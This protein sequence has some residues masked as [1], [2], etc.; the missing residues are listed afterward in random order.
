MSY[1]VNCGVE[2]DESLTACPLCA[3]RVYHPEKEEI[4]SKADSPFPKEKGEVEKVSKL[5]NVIYIS[6]L[7]LSIIIT[8]TLLNVLVFN[9][10]WWSIP[11]NGICMMLW[12]FFITAVYSEKITIYVTLMSDL[13]A[14][15]L[16]LYLISVLSGSNRWFY[17]IALPIIFVT[18]FLLELFTFLSKNISYSIMVGTMYF[19]ITVA[20]ISFT[21]EVVTDLY[22]NNK[23]AISWSAIVITVCVIIITIIGMA[24][25]IRPLRNYISKRFHI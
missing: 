20:G 3:T 4:N 8:C 12:V 15:A 24:L 23:L 5:D 6:A 19:F 13:I 2:L 22:V 25:I 9:S 14:I 1:C 11:V 7:L 17:A 18:L 10:V 16:Y 21:T